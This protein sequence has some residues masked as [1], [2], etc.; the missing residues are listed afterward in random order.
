MEDEEM[1]DL[2]MDDPV[3]LTSIKFVALELACPGCKAPIAL[4]GCLELKAEEEGAGPCCICDRCGT[5][6]YLNLRAS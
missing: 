5:V 4:A 1:S 6:A 2:V 3:V